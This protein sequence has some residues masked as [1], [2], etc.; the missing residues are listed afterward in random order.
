MLDLITRFY[1][2]VF[3]AYRGKSNFVF[4]QVTAAGVAYHMHLVDDDASHFF[5]PP[6]DESVDRRVGL[7]DGGLGRNTPAHLK[8]PNCV[9][10]QLLTSSTCNNVQKNVQ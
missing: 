9:H 7:F 2:T 4:D 10:T 3:E 8:R 6:L 1:S 5:G